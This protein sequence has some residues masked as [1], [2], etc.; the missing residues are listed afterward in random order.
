VGVTVNAPDEGQSKAKMS[1]PPS[2]GAVASGVV[3][4]LLVSSVVLLSGLGIVVA[5][6]GLIPVARFLG[7]GERGVHAWGWVLLLLGLLAISVGLPFTRTLLAA[8][9]LLVVLPALTIEAWRS[10]PWTDGR[11]AAITVL[12]GACVVLLLFGARS[13]PQ[14]P[15]QASAEMFRE[16]MVQSGMEEAMKTSSSLS[17][18]EADLRLDL[19]ERTAA[20]GLPGALVAY[21]T[22]V[23]FWIRPRLLALGLVLPIPPFERYRSEE[24]LPAVFAITGLA[25]LVLDG[26]ARWVALNLLVSVLIL[27]FV[28]GL[29]MIRAHLVRWIGRG[30]AVRWGVGLLSLQVWFLVAAL[31][32]ADSFFNLRPRV[33][34]RGETHESDSE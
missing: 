27:Y 5:P 15:V 30:W 7:T 21:L 9:L 1:R 10:R 6:L 18:G 34:D 3:S 25:T 17:R 32:L 26:T 28:H 13:W 12:A 2:L 31:G 4:L 22:M 19:L 11:W 8:Y 16:F 29:A 20:W 23:L 14:D 33:D 24:W